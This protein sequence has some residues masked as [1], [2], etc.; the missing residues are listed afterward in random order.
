MN[1]LPSPQCSFPPL[2]EDQDHSPGGIACPAHAW[3]LAVLNLLADCCP[4]T[5]QENPWDDLT[6]VPL[7]VENTCNADTSGAC[8]PHGSSTMGGWL[9]RL[10][11][12]DAGN[13][14]RAQ[15][16]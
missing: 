9:S 4:S 3:A 13:S 7:S 14:S 6:R 15:G 2:H 16:E 8:F 12:Q 5:Q 11:L 10:Q 1:I